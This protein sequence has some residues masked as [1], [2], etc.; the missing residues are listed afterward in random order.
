[1]FITLESVNLIKEIQIFIFWIGELIFELNNLLF[2]ST[3][4][5]RWKT[6]IGLIIVVVWSWSSK[7][8]SWRGLLHTL[9][10]AHFY[11]WGTKIT[12]IILWLVFT[13]WVGKTEFGWGW[14][15]DWDWSFSCPNSLL[16]LN[17]LVNTC[18]LRNL[19]SNFLFVLIP[20]PNFIFKFLILLLK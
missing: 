17:F 5:L 19:D 12:T 16:C 13:R 14:S 11:R 2:Q 3:K 4:I 9:V 20:I 6:L 8:S 18:W 1:M 7:L 15:L 10:S